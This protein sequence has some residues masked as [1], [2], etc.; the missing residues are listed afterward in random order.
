MG[1]HTFI[2]LMVEIGLVLEEKKQ[3][4]NRKKSLSILFF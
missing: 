1:Q 2:M 4:I 3:K